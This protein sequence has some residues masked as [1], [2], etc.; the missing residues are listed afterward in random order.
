MIQFLTILIV[1]AAVI[2]TFVVLIQNSKG[3]GLAAGFA[4]AN[5]VFGVKKT[6]DRIEKL[7]WILIA[8]IIVLS[9]FSA[10]MISSSHNR[11]SVSAVDTEQIEQQ[12][13][14]QSQQ[15]DMEQPTPAN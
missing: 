15:G 2:L 7:T 11:A 12:S 1:I 9:I 8:I 3:G 10:R 4:S 6:T 13:V 14:M 5:Q